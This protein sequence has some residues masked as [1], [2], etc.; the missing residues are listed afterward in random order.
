MTT[1]IA[2]HRIERR[3]DGKPD[4]TEPGDRIA[5]SD[6]EL[7]DLPVGAVRRPAEASPAGDSE[8]STGE[9]VLSVDE[10][11]AQAKT[12]DRATLTAML[13]AETSGKNRKTAVK[14]IDEAIAALPAEDAEDADEGEADDADTGQ[15][16]DNTETA[17]TPA[18]QDE[19][20]L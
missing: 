20:V 14:A 10:I 13:E 3:I 6:D 4:I 18:S 7:A 1:Y 8:E 19:E 17:S 9:G 2:N 16:E 15:T 12:A 5:L 11:K